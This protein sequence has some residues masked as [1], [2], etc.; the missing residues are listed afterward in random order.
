MIQKFS[1]K[2]FCVIFLFLISSCGYKNDENTKFF[3]KKLNLNCE[4]QK[5]VLIFY[6]SKGILKIQLFGD[7]HPVTVANFISKVK[8]NIYV[9]KNFYKIIS[10][11]NNRLIHN[12]LN[13]LN[14]FG[15]M[16]ITD[17]E[18]LASIPL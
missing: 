16:N 8:S 17:I 2:F 7:S 4:I 18:N 10:Y 6:T 11:S 14:D 15:Q 13:K 3:C 1:N 9:N 5:N 12:G